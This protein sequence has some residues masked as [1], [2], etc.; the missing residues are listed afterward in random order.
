[1]D[2]SLS[3][4]QD[5]SRTTEAFAKRAAPLGNV[6][7]TERRATERR[8][9]R[10]P[11]AARVKGLHFARVLNLSRRGALAKTAAPL[12]PLARHQLVI[13]FP[14]APFVA[15]TTVQ[16]CRGWG[17]VTDAQGHRVLSYRSGLEFDDLS[18]QAI[19]FLENNLGVPSADSLHPAIPAGDAGRAAL[20]AERRL[21]REGGPVRIRVK[22]GWSPQGRDGSAG[23]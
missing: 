11:I 15:R 14:D 13:E 20:L 6:A 18:R 10:E 3:S 2:R 23:H 16:R 17:Q 8:A 21:A 19:E 1:M 12:R 22:T 5:S 9:V 4:N 7:G